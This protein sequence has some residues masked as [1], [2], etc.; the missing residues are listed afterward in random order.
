[1][2]PG[3]IRFGGSTLD[4]PT[5]ANSSGAIRSAIPTTAGRSAPGAGFSRPALVLKSSCSS[6]GWSKPSL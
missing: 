1:M 4:D 6:A 3:I 5:W 2:R